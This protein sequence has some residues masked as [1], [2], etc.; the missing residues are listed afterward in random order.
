MSTPTVTL[1][2]EGNLEGLQA[3]WWRGVADRWPEGAAPPHLQLLSFDDVMRD[4]GAIV[5]SVAVVFFGDEEGSSTCSPLRFGEALHERGV[6][7]VFLFPTIDKRRCAMNSECVMVASVDAPPGQL[8]WALA[9][10]AQRQPAVETMQHELRTTRRFQTGLRGEMDRVHE[11]LQLAAQVQ[12]DFLPQGLPTIPGLDVGVLFRPCGYVSGDIYD[13]LRLDE[14]HAGFFIADAIGHGVPAALMTM[15][16]CRSLPMK[17]IIGDSYR[18]VP[19]SEALTRL[20]VQL[21]KHQGESPRFASAVYG[22]INTETGEVTIAGAGHPP[23]LRYSD[24][25]VEKVE[26]EGGLLG[27]FPNET[28]Q[29]TKFTL[30]PDEVLMLHSDGFETAFP[31]V[32]A[33]AYGRRLPTMHY[34]RHFAGVAERVRDGAPHAP[35]FLDLARSLDGQAG[36]LHQV[37]DVTAIALVR[38]PVRPTDG[39]FNASTRIISAG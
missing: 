10:L 35:A 37:D 18:I 29:Q 9:A 36:S 22:I 24:R 8:A 27:V 15:V 7:S 38:V 20:N 16:L 26:T 3:S 39:L 2:A 13:V 33:D 23:P 17:E 34:L 6:A 32:H 14:T 5:G 30:A 19:P 31:D 28:Y 12:R 4:R 1:I 25:G 11:E 21:I